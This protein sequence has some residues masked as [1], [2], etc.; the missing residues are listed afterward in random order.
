MTEPAELR[1]GLQLDRKGNFATMLRMKQLLL[2]L[3]MVLGLVIVVTLSHS[4]A[5]L[6]GIL[7]ATIVLAAA[8]VWWELRK[9]RKRK[10]TVES[11][12]HA[13][14]HIRDSWGYPPKREQV[15][16]EILSGNEAGDG[17]DYA[18]HIHEGAEQYLGAD[19]FSRLQQRF[20]S[21]AGVDQ[22]QHE[23]REVFLIRTKTLNA[24]G[25]KAACWKQFLEAAKIAFEKKGAP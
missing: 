5:V 19:Q 15:L 22:C 17:W 13:S 8:A 12:T 10:A 11:G 2:A 14:T 3:A 18:V 6:Y 9:I 25:L 16:E 1:G 21:V 7:A 4:D 20:A 24:D 23:D